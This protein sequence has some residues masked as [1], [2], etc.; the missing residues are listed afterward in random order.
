M[1]DRLVVICYF[2]A[3]RRWRWTGNALR[4]LRRPPS[5]DELRPASAATGKRTSNAQPP[6]LNS[7]LQPPDVGCY[8]EV[9]AEDRGRKGQRIGLARR[10]GD[11]ALIA[12]P[13]IVNWS[14]LFTPCAS[15]AWSRKAAQRVHGVNNSDRAGW[16]DHGFG[17][18]LLGPAWLVPPRLTTREQPMYGWR[19][20]GR[21]EHAAQLNES[22]D[23][24]QL[25]RSSI[26]PSPLDRPPRR[27]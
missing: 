8:G 27:Y 24:S 13:M 12:P 3:A 10:G 20:I 22:S 14:E 2:W 11:N 1:T 15:A 5:L 18:R 16:A 17:P 7:D 25:N 4:A 21:D 6:T 23:A 19:P 26:S 9:R